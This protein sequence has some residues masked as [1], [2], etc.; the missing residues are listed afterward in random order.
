MADPRLPLEAGREV[1]IHVPGCERRTD[2]DARREISPVGMTETRRST[3]VVAGPAKHT[4]PI[5]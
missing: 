1:S 2:L 5:G 4:M 3:W